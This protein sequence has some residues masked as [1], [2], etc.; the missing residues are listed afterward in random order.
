MALATRHPQAGLLHHSD[1]G[2]EFTSERY[3]AV[4]REAGIEARHDLERETVMTMR[5]W[6]AFFSTL[7]KECT[8]RVRLPTRQE[9]RSTIFEYLVVPFL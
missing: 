5:R 4:L 2:S 6:K 3:Q 9:A 7:T 1:R 8:E